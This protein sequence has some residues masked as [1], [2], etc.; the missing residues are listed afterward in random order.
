MKFG[1]MKLFSLQLCTYAL[2]LLFV[3]GELVDASKHRRYKKK[4]K[5]GDRTCGYKVSFAL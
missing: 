5:L 1:R 2:L 4:D 3:C